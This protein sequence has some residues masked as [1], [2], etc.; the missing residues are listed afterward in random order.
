MSFVNIESLVVDGGAGDD[1]FFVLGTSAG[2][3]DRDR[4]R[5]RLRR[6][7][8]SRARRPANGVIANTC[9]GTAASST[10]DVESLGNCPGTCTPDGGDYAGIDVVGIS[11]NVADNDTPGVVV[12]PSDGS[13]SVFEGNGTTF[14]VHRRARRTRSTS[15]SRGRPARTSRSASRS[16]RPKGLVLLDASN[17]P[18]RLTSNE[19]QVISLHNVLN[20][21]F[22]VTL[23]G[24]TDPTHLNWDATA[25]AF[26][27]VL[28]HLLKNAPITLP[29]GVTPGMLVAADIDVEQDGAQ[30]TI[31]F[32][33]GGRLSH[34]T[35]ARSAP[36]S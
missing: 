14:S 31:N 21:H 8:A 30:Y 10:H 15:C 11:A 2:L 36:R 33:D 24:Y 20:Q 3:D 18:Q 7:S 25:S 16:S 26:A 6:R 34:G 17:N 5:P 35:S 28:L 4:R 23:G 32:V 12:T 9:S 27:G 29:S 13:S 22:S 1:R 19:T